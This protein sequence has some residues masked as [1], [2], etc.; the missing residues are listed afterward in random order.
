MLYG[1]LYGPHNEQY[2]RGKV[3]TSGITIYRYVANVSLKP[4]HFSKI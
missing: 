3:C 4:P 1:V 2:K